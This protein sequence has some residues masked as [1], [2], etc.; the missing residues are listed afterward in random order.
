MRGPVTPTSEDDAD[1][2]HLLTKRLPG[3]RGVLDF[4]IVLLFQYD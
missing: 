2:R 3:H 4:R 1:A